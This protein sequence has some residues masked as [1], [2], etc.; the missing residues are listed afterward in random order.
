M[1]LVIFL[2]FSLL[3]SLI[4]AQTS[5]RAQ[6]KGVLTN[7]SIHCSQIKHQLFQSTATTDA[8]RYEWERFL[9]V[10]VKTQLFDLQKNKRAGELEF[11]ETM[12]HGKFHLLGPVGP[13][14][15]TPIESYG[16]ADDEKRVCG[17]QQLQKI[18]QVKSQDGQKHECVV[19]SIG[20]NNQWGFEEA[21]IEKTEC[22][23]E[24]FDCTL[25]DNFQ[26]PSHL[27]DRVRFHAICL[28]DSDYEVNGRR[29][30]SWETLNKLTG[31]L[32]QP[33]FL[34]M[35]IEGYEF[36]VLRSIVDSGVFLPLQIAVEVHFIRAVNSG[37]DWRRVSSVELYSFINY[38]YKYGGYYL[39]DRHDNPL[40][41][42]CTEIVLAKLNCENHPLPKNYQEILLAN[43]DIQH[44]GYL[45]AVKDSL[46]TKYYG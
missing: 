8:Q 30:V 33:T 45:S 5:H 31:V 32:T 24:T 22:R 2:Y 23:I 41:V 3:P 21:I 42:S 18:N 34:K 26:L 36:P 20:S 16:K 1:L 14:C 19:Y 38:I 28:S 4:L 29:F 12:E 40:C 35:D 15:K 37:I 25:G 46:K 9:P 11:P 43:E 6:F 39:I 13:R 44:S 17:L 27:K 7:D 10:F